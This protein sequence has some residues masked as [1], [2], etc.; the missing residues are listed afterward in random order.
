MVIAL[1]W[2]IGS[3]SARTVFASSIVY[4]Q[5]LPSYISTNSF[6]LSCTSNGTSAQFYVNKNGAGNVAFGP[7][8]NLATTQ[9]LVPVTSTQVNDQTN[10]TFTVIVDGGPSA[11]TSTFFDNSGPSGV[12]GYYKERVNDGK[13]KLHWRNPG[14]SD[15]DKVVIYRGESADF[16]ADNSHEIARVSGGSNSDMTYDDNFTPDANKTYFY[17]IRALDHA[18]NS[19]SLVGD[20]GTIASSTSS[21][22]GGVLGA[23]TT[24]KSTIVVTPNG[25]SVLGTEDSATATSQAT[26]AQNGEVQNNVEDTGFLRWIMNHKKI[27]LG[28]V[29]LA[30]LV[31]HFLRSKK[32]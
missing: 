20:S 8:I 2:T 15:F 28:F 22:S 14:D 5:T 23:T 12:S 1:A 4:I 9:C 31:Y 21:T 24:P 30:L 19:S 27:S 29:A 16:S 25:G 13:Y 18:G 3:F 32:S 6:N 10:Y 11:S 7:I 17:A 26:T